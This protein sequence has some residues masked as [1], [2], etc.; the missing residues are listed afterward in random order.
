VVPIDAGFPPVT[1]TTRRDGVASDSFD[2]RFFL[3]KP[4]RRGPDGE[5][6]GRR[7]HDRALASI[8]ENRLDIV[9]NVTLPFSRCCGAA[10]SSRSPGGR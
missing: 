7:G 8:S 10:I 4:L 3:M 2:N 9:A 6:G 5:P 1:Y